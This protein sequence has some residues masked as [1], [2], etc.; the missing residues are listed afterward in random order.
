M[1]TR[2]TSPIPAKTRGHASTIPSPMYGESELGVFCLTGL[3]ASRSC[4]GCDRIQ[5][6]TAT[7]ARVREN[8][9]EESLEAERVVQASMKLLGTAAHDLRQPV[10]AIL[11]YGE[12]L[13]EDAEST[14]TTEQAQLLHEIVSISES[15]LR[16]L[17]ESLEL[18]NTET[19]TVRL[20]IAP[21]FLVQAVAQSVSLNSGIAARK[22]IRLQLV[23]QDEPQPVLLDVLKISNVFNNLI[24]NAIKYCQPGAEIYVRISRSEDEVLASVQDNGPGIAPEDLKNL[25]TPFQ[26]TQAQARSDEPGAGLGLSI[27]KHIVDLHAGRIR[28]ETE[29]GKGTTFYVSLPIHALPAQASLSVPRAAGAANSR[30]QQKF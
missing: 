12:M 6:L 3:R 21:A 29:I 5:H 11:A 18:A 9:R 7:L 24:G 17:E 27:A 1:L 22:Q 19:G 8:A 30:R 13:A 15:A 28:V 26:K 14:L 25:F 20:R 2:S 16:L 23:E 10:A 4:E